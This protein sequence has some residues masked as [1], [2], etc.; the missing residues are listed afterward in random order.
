M[1]VSPSIQKPQSVFDI[2][3][4]SFTHKCLHIVQILLDCVEVEEETKKM[5]H[6]LVKAMKQ[7]AKSRP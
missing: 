1:L 6:K 7:A 4:Y 2:N 3:F 5:Y